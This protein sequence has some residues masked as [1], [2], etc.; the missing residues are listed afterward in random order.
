MVVAE[1]GSS[2]TPEEDH[3]SLLSGSNISALHSSVQ[4][5]TELEEGDGK[6]AS[7]IGLVLLPSVWILYVDSIQHGSTRHILFPCAR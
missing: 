4:C 3:E 5:H 7:P 6:E 2:S 1:L